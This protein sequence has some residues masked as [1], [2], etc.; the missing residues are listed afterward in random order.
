MS[1]Q[2]GTDLVIQE[3]GVHALNEIPRAMGSGTP[4]AW[5]P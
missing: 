4:R 1:T 5:S 2:D 3:S